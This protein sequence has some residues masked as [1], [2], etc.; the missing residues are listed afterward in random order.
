MIAFTA[1]LALSPLE[2]VLAVVRVPQP[3]IKP[4]PTPGVSAMK[5]SEQI[6][7][8]VVQTGKLIAV[9]FCFVVGLFPVALGQLVVLFVTD[10]L[11][12]AVGLP[13]EFV[14]GSVT[15]IPVVESEIAAV[16]KPT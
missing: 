15:V 16:A 4:V 8:L 6:P 13:P 2:I 9:P 11:A 3:R 10:T 14:G 5:K 12:Y 7:Q 1:K